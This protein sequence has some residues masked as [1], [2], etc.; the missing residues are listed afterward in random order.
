LNFQLSVQLT[1]HIMELLDPYFATSYFVYRDPYEELFP[2][3]PYKIQNRTDKHRSVIISSQFDHTWFLITSVVLHVPVYLINIMSVPRLNLR[4][5]KRKGINPPAATYLSA[6]RFLCNSLST[7][8]MM[9]NRHSHV[10]KT[11]G[12]LKLVILG[13]EDLIYSKAWIKFNSIKLKSCDSP[14]GLCAI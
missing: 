6:C 7:N 10:V 5:H 3:L 12:S 8:L 11:W 9:A 13:G 1:T 2:K 14:I 4:R